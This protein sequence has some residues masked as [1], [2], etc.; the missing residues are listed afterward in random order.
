MCSLTPSSLLT[1]HQHLKTTWFPHI[2]LLCPKKTFYRT[3]K[4]QTS[5]ELVWRG[6]FAGEM[7]KERTNPEKSSADVV[8]PPWVMQQAEV[9]ERREREKQKTQNQNVY[10]FT[11]SA[12]SCLIPPTRVRAC[13]VR[14]C[15]LRCYL[16]TPTD[17]CGILTRVRAG[18]GV[19]VDVQGA[20]LGNESIAALCFSIASTRS[21]SCF[22]PARK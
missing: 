3:S 10:S 1:R 8:I 6:P 20:S 22:F 9:S 15:A 2:F 4:E 21:S 12:N 13:G 7:L 17:T 11:T 5:A 19:H 16:Y 18:G 14:A